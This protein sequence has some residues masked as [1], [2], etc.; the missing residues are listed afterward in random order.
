M[1]HIIN[2]LF[3]NIAKYKMRI[4]M[5]AAYELMKEDQFQKDMADHM[6]QAIKLMNSDNM[7]I[8][9]DALE[10]AIAKEFGAEIKLNDW[11]N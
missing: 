10:A 2:R 6:I 8:V 4:T 1:K 3:I 5:R 7:V 11:R 9:N